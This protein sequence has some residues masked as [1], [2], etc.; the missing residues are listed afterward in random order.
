[1]MAYGKCW[2]LTSRPVVRFWDRLRFLCGVPL[3]V[4]FITPDGNCHAA[5]NIET[6]VQT[7]WPD[8]PVEREK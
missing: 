4:R 8:E 2:Y 1:M 3:Y 5:C 6:Y 7:D